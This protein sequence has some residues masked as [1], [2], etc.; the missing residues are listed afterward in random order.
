VKIST[1][2]SRPL[3]SSFEYG[4]TD[5]KCWTVYNWHTRTT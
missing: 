1:T 5:E 3:S 2:I 4:K